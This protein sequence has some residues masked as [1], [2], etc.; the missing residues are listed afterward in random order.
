MV[1]TYNRIAINSNEILTHAGTWM[2]SEDIM[3]TERNQSQK[4]RQ[5]TYLFR[6][7]QLSKIVRILEPESEIVVAR[8]WGI[9]EEHGELLM[10]RHNISIMHAQ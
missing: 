2:N 7:Y 8:S 3:L 10:D 9:G 5:Y 4:D 1:H 6:F